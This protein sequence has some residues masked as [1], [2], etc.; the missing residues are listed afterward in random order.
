MLM[1][2]FFS[3]RK[4]VSNPDKPAGKSEEDSLN[5]GTVIGGVTGGIIF[6]TILF[7]LR[8]IILRKLREESVRVMLNNLL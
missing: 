1:L 3:V 6:L 2:F 8:R 4:Q 5:T 7:L